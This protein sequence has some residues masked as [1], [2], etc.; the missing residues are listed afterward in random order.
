[1][2][3]CVLQRCAEHEACSNLKGFVP[4]RLISLGDSNEDIR[5]SESVPTCEG[6]RWAALSHCW[7]G[8]SP[9]KLLQANLFTLQQR[10]DYTTLP[11]TF[12]NAIEVVR[13]LGIYYLWIDS[14]CIVQ[15]DKNDWEL[16]AARMGMVY[17]RAFVVLCA[18]SSPNP[19]TSF[20]GQRD[21][22]WLPKMFEFE[23]VQGDN[24]PIM[25][26]QRHLLAAP[27]GQGSYE[28]PFTS[29]WASL[30]PVGPLY[31]RGWCFQ[32]TFLATRILHFAPGAII[33]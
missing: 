33:F 3:E 15:D 12:C 7:D 26:R 9:C 18:A 22:M 27:L 29:A 11:A 16:E 13:E 8:S 14:L 1:M 28:P 4:S 32:E 24:V 6:I 20:L 19:Q 31:K 25:V 30:K 23:T 17:G 21:E 10:I 5:L 2:K